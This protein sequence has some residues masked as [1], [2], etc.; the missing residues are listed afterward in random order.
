MGFAMIFITTS[1]FINGNVIFAYNKEYEV[2]KECAI[3]SQVPNKKSYT[4]RNRN[5]H[6]PTFGSFII[7]SKILFYALNHLKDTGEV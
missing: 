1:Y 3:F 5:F 7:I 2:C 6:L 4:A